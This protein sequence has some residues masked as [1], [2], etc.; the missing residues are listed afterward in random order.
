MKGF[1]HSVSTFF[2]GL[3]FDEPEIQP[4][5]FHFLIY[6]SARSQL[7][8]WAQQK[9]EAHPS[10]SPP[11]PPRLGCISVL[12]HWCDP[13]AYMRTVIWLPFVLCLHWIPL[14]L[15][16]L[17]HDGF[18]LCVFACT[19]VWRRNETERKQLKVDG[20]VSLPTLAWNLFFFITFWYVSVCRLYMCFIMCSLRMLCNISQVLWLYQ[21]QSSS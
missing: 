9:G 14:C 1:Y 20:C 18:F 15:L 17:N 10:T 21:A 11:S 12:L 5:W 6:S 13:H 8:E 16:P 3:R 4:P 7:S 19:C 2:N